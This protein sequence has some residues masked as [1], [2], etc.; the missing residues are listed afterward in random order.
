[1]NNPNLPERAERLVKWSLAPWERPAVMGDLQEE[2]RDFAETVGEPAAQTWYWRQALASLWPNFMRRL[3]GDDARYALWSQGMEQF[4]CGCVWLAQVWAI[5]R[6]Y[7]ASVGAAWMIFGAFS[8]A[9]SIL[10][11]RVSAPRVKI[12]VESIVTLMAIVGTLLAVKQ[13]PQAPQQFLWAS[14]LP[15]VAVRLW[16][17]WPADPPPAEYLVSHRADADQDPG[18]LLTITVPNV[19]LG[20][21]GLVLIHAPAGAIVA[22]PGPI[23]HNAPTLD[24]TFAPAD[25]VRVCAVVNLAGPSAEATVD[26]VDA[27]GRIAQTVQTTVD[28]GALEAVVKKWDDIADEE[29]AAHFGQV[30]VMLPLANL[31]PGPYRLRVTASDAAHTSRQEES[32]VVRID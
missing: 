24:R 8:I 4:A 14:L 30:D 17:W 2:F 13:W 27:A 1:V 19:P 7:K 23:R 16:P 6:P 10:R 29:P 3:R 22:A 20:M 5:G 32:I 9:E 15:L 28:A 31:A 25:A 11:K 26:V 18:G 12:S 21:S